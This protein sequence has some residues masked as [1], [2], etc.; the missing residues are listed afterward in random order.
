[1]AP[2]VLSQDELFLKLY[3]H[4]PKEIVFER[5]LLATRL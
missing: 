5:E 4:L 1:V 2:G 3:T